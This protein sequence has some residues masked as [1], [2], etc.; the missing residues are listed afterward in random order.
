MFYHKCVGICLRILS[1]IRFSDISKFTVASVEVKVMV[2]MDIMVTVEME[3]S[4]F[5]KARFW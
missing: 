5:R 4:G 3:R 1:M 2:S